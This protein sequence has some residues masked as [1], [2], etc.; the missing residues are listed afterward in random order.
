MIP[1]IHSSKA[2]FSFCSVVLFSLQLFP[3]IV[4]RYML[5]AM[6]YNSD[7]ARQRFP[8]LLQ[9]VEMYPD[10]RE[11]FIKKVAFESYEG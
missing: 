5:K 8:R 10:T 9:I 6:C 11:A 1:L 4:V 3:G 7:E 2:S